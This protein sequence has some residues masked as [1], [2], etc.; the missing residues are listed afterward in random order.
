MRWSAALHRIAAI[1]ASRRAISRCGDPPRAG[2]AARAFPGVPQLWR[3]RSGPMRCTREAPWRGAMTDVPAPPIVRCSACSERWLGE[4]GDAGGRAI[5]LPAAERAARRQGG[6]GHGVLSLRRAAV[7]QRGRCRRAALQRI[8][9]PSSTRHA[10]QRRE[11]F[12]DAMLATA[13]HDHKRGE[14]VRR[15]ARG[16]ERDSAGVGTRRAALVR[17]ERARTGA[18]AM[19]RCR[20]RATR[21]CCTR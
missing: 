4:A 8:R 9:R 7:A 13:T 2:G 6:G 18:T 1:A 5:A 21:R 19:R 11:H 17:A 20:H 15:A 3:R 16:A 14:D 12:P 10:W